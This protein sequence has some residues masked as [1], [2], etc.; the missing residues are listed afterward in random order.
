MTSAV[1]ADRQV[2]V[3]PSAAH[4]HLSSACP[5][6]QLVAVTAAPASGP[7][8]QQ[9]SVAKSDAKLSLYRT[10]GLPELVWDWTP[11]ARPLDASGTAPTPAAAPPA[12]KGPLAAR[13]AL[14]RGKQKA[15]AVET[16]VQAITWHP[17]GDYLAAVVSTIENSVKSWSVHYLQVDSGQS[18][19]APIDLPTHTKSVTHASWQTLSSTTDP[20]VNLHARKVILKFKNLPA[21]PKDPTQLPGATAVPGASGIGAGA[22]AAGAATRQ[23]AAAS[24]LFG[25]KNAMLQRERE[26]E[27]G[28]ALQMITSA[29][30]WPA[31]LPLKQVDP[32]RLPEWALSSVLLIGDTA[33]TVH[34]FLEGTIYLAS[35]GLEQDSSIVAVQL[36]NSPGQQPRICVSVVRSGS[37]LLQTMLQP[38]LPAHMCQ[39]LVQVDL[40]RQMMQHA[41]DAL[42]E[43]RTIWDESRRLGKGWLSRISDLS[44]SH[45]VTRPAISQL[46]LLLTTGRPSLALQDFLASKMNERALDKWIS[47]T[48]QAFT[49]LRKNTVLS[50]QP[51]VERVILMLDELKGWTLYKEKFAAYGLRPS[52]IG[53]AVLLATEIIKASVRFE[54]LVVEEQRCF[55]EFVFWIRYQFEKTAQQ[56]NSGPRPPANYRPVPVAHFIRRS[57]SESAVAPFLDFGLATTPLDNNASLKAG[58]AWLDSIEIDEKT[59]EP[60]D[61]DVDWLDKVSKLVRR[62]QQ[63]LQGQFDAEDLERSDTERQQ[64][65]RPR[66]N[67]HVPFSNPET[68][69]LPR[70]PDPDVRSRAFERPERESE[71]D[72]LDTRVRPVSTLPTPESLSI[73][74]HL[75]ASLVSG[76]LQESVQGVGRRI[77]LSE[78]ENVGSCASD[79]AVRARAIQLS[80]TKQAILSV[81]LDEDA[82]WLT[83]RD[84]QT[85]W[86]KRVGARLRLSHNKEAVVVAFDFLDDHQLLVALKSSSVSGPEYLLGSVSLQWLLSQSG[87]EASIPSIELS[88]QVGLDKNYP[89]EQISVNGD[90]QVRSVYVLSSEGRRLEVVPWPEDEQSHNTNGMDIAMS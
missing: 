43:G 25:A 54:N 69:E 6:R 29:K 40:L 79:G 19:I 38:K 45:A 84:E 51:A 36:V 90:S 48:E 37:Q 68:S 52:W 47:T 18:P 34:I 39:F 49:K 62:M 27:A 3:L 87:N 33:G 46:L 21:L 9:S 16:H 17:S 10:S 64:A 89:P 35:V 15:S 59:F 32:E 72:M 42:Q 65:Q 73:M 26:K 22:A 57:L 74:L 4:L 63:E 50:I 30:N 76:H 67:I 28:R 8:S 70:F 58:Q 13:A 31:L 60:I 75:L 61:D 23:G 53:K 7:Q 85:C 86:K 1:T 41:V 71:P 11:P 12:L 5:R 55:N 88:R 83:E 44:S 66:T 81:W 80:K 20:L 2:R 77:S 14:L 56:E 78:S 82:L 24:A